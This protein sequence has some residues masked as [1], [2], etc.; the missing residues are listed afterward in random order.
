MRPVKIVALVLVVSRAVRPVAVPIR[1]KKEVD[2]LWGEFVQGHSPN[3]MR[4][5]Q[6]GIQAFRVGRVQ[7]EGRRDGSRIEQ[8]ALEEVRRS[9]SRTMAI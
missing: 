7:G 5:R 9:S 6:R 2:I 4:R 3:R 1:E 8:P